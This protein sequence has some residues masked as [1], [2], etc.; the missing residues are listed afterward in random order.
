[1]DD[2]PVV[3][4]VNEADHPIRSAIQLTDRELDVLRRVV[5]GERNRDIAAALR[6][7]PRTVEAHVSHILQKLGAR[8]RSGAGWHAVQLGLVTMEDLTAIEIP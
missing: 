5:S 3:S 8:S 2:P 6:I 7:S 1:M 4:I